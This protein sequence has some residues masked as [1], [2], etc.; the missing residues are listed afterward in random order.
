ML[1]SQ[2]QEI[3]ATHR[4]D[5][6]HVLVSLSRRGA[7]CVCLELR[8]D[9][10]QAAVL[11]AL[12]PATRTRLDLD[13]GGCLPHVL[14]VSGAGRDGLETPRNTELASVRHIYQCESSGQNTLKK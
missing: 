5:S 12:D 2:E 10:H 9:V 6:T 7:A 11:H 1:P 13:G 8:D 14:G 3:S 4:A